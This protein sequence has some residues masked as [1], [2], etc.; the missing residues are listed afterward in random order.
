[1]TNPTTETAIP[2]DLAAF[3][4]ADESRVEIDLPNGDPMLYNGQRVVVVVFGP[5]TPEWSAAQA[6]KEQRATAQVFAAMGKKP[7]AKTDAAE[8]DAQ[9]LA[10]ITKGIEN[11]PWPG[12]PL[13]IYREKGLMYIPHQVQRH[14]NDLGNFYAPS[15][16]S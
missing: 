10:S 5:S 11:F 8:V 7:K 12:G 6:L 13:G 2:A 4:L 15:A 16:T 9:Y 3:L 1:M 14:L